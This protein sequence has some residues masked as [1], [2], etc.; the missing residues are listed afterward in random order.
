MISTVV[1]SYP[2]I[3]DL[4]AERRLRDVQSRGGAGHI[5]LFSHRDEV[6]EV[7]QFHRGRRYLSGIATQGTWYFRGGST[8]R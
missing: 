5:L 8:A 3:P 4:P 7:S 1:G 2:K 6:S